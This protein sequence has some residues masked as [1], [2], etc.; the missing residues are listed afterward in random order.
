MKWINNK[1]RM[2]SYKQKSNFKRCQ[3]W[4]C[5]M[6][7]TILKSKSANAPHN[8]SETKTKWNDHRNDFW[9]WNINENDVVYEDWLTYRLQE[10]NRISVRNEQTTTEQT[11]Q[12]HVLQMVCARILTVKSYYYDYCYGYP[13]K[14]Q[15]PSTWIDYIYI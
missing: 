8:K 2:L 6:Q 4:F 14:F 9:C 11:T 7:K 10:R 15:I 5:N 12:M 1:H 3:I 13:K